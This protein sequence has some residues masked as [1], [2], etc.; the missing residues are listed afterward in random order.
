MRDN[1]RLSG[2]AE[3]VKGIGRVEVCHNEQWGLICANHWS[4]SES[5]VACRQLGYDAAFALLVGPQKVRE[6]TADGIYTPPRRGR[7]TDGFT[8]WSVTER[9]ISFKTAP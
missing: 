3:T 6:W 7:E 9:N 2:A 4:E 8:L 5:I 1:L